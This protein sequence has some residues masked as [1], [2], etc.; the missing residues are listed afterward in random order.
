[1]SDFDFLRPK[2][3]R[4]QP[5]A[6]SVAPEPDAYLL[7]GMAYM[8]AD[9]DQEAIDAA[10]PLFAHPPRVPLTDAELKAI[11]SK[12]GYKSAMCKSFARAIE[13]AHGIGTGRAG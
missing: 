10:L 3:S 7:D 8:P 5:T 4:P 11:W 6:P 9:L 13:V 2:S 1:M 12:H